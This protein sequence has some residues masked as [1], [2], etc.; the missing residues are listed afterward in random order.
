MFL[1]GSVDQP[2]LNPM[3]MSLRNIDHCVFYGIKESPNFDKATKQF[4]MRKNASLGHD[5]SIFQNFHFSQFSATVLNKLCNQKI[6]QNVD[7]HF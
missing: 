5:I 1:R 3:C 6:H 2:S 7:Y 4:Y